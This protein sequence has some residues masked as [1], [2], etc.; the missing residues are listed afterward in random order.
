MTQPYIGEVRMF[1][2]DYAPPGW[3]LC[4]GDLLE[5]TDHEPLF[6]VIGTTYGGDGASTF[7]LP[8]LR[9]RVPI[10]N[11]SGFALGTA[12]GAESVTLAAP[13]LPAHTHAVRATI[14]A[15]TSI[16]PGGGVLAQTSGIKPYIEDAA[17]VGMSPLAVGDTGAGQAHTNL[18]PYLCVHF[19]IALYGSAL[20]PA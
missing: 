5:I 15:G 11:G 4:N 3:L 19:I 18:Q 16:N 17:V 13:Q 2:G 20:S 6:D 1:A 12:D 14:A 9:G 7:A 8:D 10:H